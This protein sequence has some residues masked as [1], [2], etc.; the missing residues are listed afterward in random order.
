LFLLQRSEEWEKK[1]IIRNN[2]RI[3]AISTV[4]L[5]FAENKL[6]IILFGIDKE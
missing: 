2:K 4:G 3:I 6:I 5:E 1:E